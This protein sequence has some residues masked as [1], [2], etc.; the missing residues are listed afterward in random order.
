MYLLLCSK[1]SEPSF[2]LMTHWIK[3][4]EINGAALQPNGYELW[5]YIVIFFGGTKTST[6][7]FSGA[8]FQSKSTIK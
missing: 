3:P 4:S 6:S 5:G 1:I 7:A 2:P 8:V